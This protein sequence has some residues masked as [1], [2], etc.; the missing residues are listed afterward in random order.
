MNA[1]ISKEKIYDKIVEGGMLSF[2]PIYK[3]IFLPWIDNISDSMKQLIYSN[4][5]FHQKD[6]A[7]MGI[8]DFHQ[9]RNAKK[10]KYRT[11]R[12]KFKLYSHTYF[13][14]LTVVVL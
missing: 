4:K 3:F 7:Q 2:L 14:Y 11:I 10:E 12:L 13:I 9:I 8:S 1:K 5:K 6:K